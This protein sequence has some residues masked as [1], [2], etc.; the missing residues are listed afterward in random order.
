MGLFFHSAISSYLLPP[1][2]WV[3]T[4]RIDIYVFAEVLWHSI[5][6]AHA[7]HGALGHYHPYIADRQAV[8]C[9]TT[10][11]EIAF[12][13]ADCACRTERRWTNERTWSPK[14]NGDHPFAI[15]LSGQLLSAPAVTS[16]IRHTY[17]KRAWI[18]SQWFLLNL[19][20]ETNWPV[21]VTHSEVNVIL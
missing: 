12:N 11:F 4:F 8:K 14:C 5:V 9:V 6:H 10:Y 17:I 19:W 13:F 15:R 21:T 16:N 2:E 1:C 3:K 18:L 7:A 20:Y